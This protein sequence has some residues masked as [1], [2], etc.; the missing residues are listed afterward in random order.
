ML[1]GLRPLFHCFNDFLFLITQLRDHH[2]SGPSVD[3]QLTGSSERTSQHMTYAHLNRGY[4]WVIISIEIVAAVVN[5]NLSLLNAELCY[6]CAFHFHKIN[7]P[8]HFLYL[9]CRSKSQ[10]F[11]NVR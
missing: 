1:L 3:W 2:F 8:I 5:I 6:W 4:C 11:V 10:G 7:R 9:Y